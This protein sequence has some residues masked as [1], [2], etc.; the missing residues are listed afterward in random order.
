MD[1]ARAIL[2][3]NRLDWAYDTAVDFD[4]L[5]QIAM[6]ELSRSLPSYSY[7]SRFSTWAYQV[8]TRGVQ[9]NLRNMAAKKRTAI[10]GYR[11]DPLHLIHTI[12]DSDHPESHIYDQA[13]R[14][15]ITET[16]T[17]ALGVRNAQVFTLWVYGDLSAEMIGRRI[18]LST[19]RVHAIL[20]QARQYLRGYEPVLRWRDAM[21]GEETMPRGMVH[22]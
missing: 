8:I 20:S 21:I 16:L 19:P 10:I 14:T 17:R 12:A 13:L 4:D 1:H 11:I 15:L 7:K 3:H 9:R 18:G 5:A 22:S 2:R 6:L